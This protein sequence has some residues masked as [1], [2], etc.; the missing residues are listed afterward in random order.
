MSG[1]NHHGH[2]IFKIIINT[3]NRLLTT[4]NRS[5]KLTDGSSSG[6]ITSMVHQSALLFNGYYNK[7]QELQLWILYSNNVCTSFCRAMRVL[8]SNGLVVEPSGAAAFAAFLSKKVPG[9]E[10]GANVVIFLT[11][12]NASLEEMNKFIGHSNV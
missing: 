11:G 9:I 2:V 4:I 5:Q 7:C 3:I 10:A 12:A 8:F 1:F 6:K